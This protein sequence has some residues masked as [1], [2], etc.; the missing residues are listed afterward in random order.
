MNAKDGVS[1]RP[2]GGIVS[3]SG[4]FPACLSENPSYLLQKYLTSTGSN[5][6]TFAGFWMWVGFVGFFFPSKL[7]TCSTKMLVYELHSVPKPKCLQCRQIKSVWHFRKHGHLVPYTW[8]PGF[9]STETLSKGLKTRKQRMSSQLLTRATH[10]QPFTWNHILQV[11]VMFL[12]LDDN[13]FSFHTLILSFLTAF[14][15]W[16]MLK[17]TSQFIVCL[18]YE[19]NHHCRWV[20]WLMG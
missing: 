20:S 3:S 10:E 16:M 17:S 18:F 11:F 7:L 2:T 6:T 15:Q 13:K 5:K 9:F 4:H 14:I 12:L 19:M 8:K 1:V